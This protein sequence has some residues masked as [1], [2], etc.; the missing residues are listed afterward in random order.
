MTKDT[1]ERKT[2]INVVEENIFCREQLQEACTFTNAFV[3]YNLVWNVSSASR[4]NLC[5]A[6]RL[7]CIKCK[8]YKA[9]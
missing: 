1:N 6:F 5:E 4:N 3:S 7:N 8:S 2:G 9:I